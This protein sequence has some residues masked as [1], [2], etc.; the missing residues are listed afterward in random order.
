[1]ARRVG[2]LGCEMSAVLFVNTKCFACIKNLWSTIKWIN[3]VSHFLEP[4]STDRTGLNHRHHY[5]RNTFINSQDT[6]SKFRFTSPGNLA[7][8]KYNIY[9]HGFCE[10]SL[11]IPFRS[12]ICFFLPPLKTI[13]N[14]WL[15]QSHAGKIRLLQL[16]GR[17]KYDWII[18][19]VL[20]SVKFINVDFLRL[21]NCL[22]EAGW[23]LFRRNP[24]IKLWKCM[25]SNPRPH[26]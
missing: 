23:I 8:M 7:T 10:V 17:W 2:S 16:F 13:L 3:D 19:L 9:A 14:L 21:S 1:M 22:H 6:L 18:L 15:T 24:Q 12:Q 20:H 25:V 26:A 11:W 4:Q 5:H